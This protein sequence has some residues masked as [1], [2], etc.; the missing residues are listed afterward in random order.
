M[1]RIPA[2]LPECWV[3]NLRVDYP[4]YKSSRR[5]SDVVVVLHTPG[6]DAKGNL[7]VWGL[8]VAG[9]RQVW[10]WV[11]EYTNGDEIAESCC[12]FNLSDRRERGTKDHSFIRFQLTA[13]VLAQP[14]QS[15][16]A[17]EPRK[18]S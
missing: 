14:I 16:A 13:R 7:D 18:F 4:C 1:R 15:P 12:I 6:K 3:D 11:V 10:N 8:H 5:C 9:A 17:G 2:I